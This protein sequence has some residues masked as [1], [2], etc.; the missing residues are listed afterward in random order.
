MI[1]D[2]EILAGIQQKILLSLPTE[3]ETRMV[4]LI[5]EPATVSEC[6]E[7]T[8]LDAISC[9]PDLLALD[10]DIVLEELKEER[11]VRARIQ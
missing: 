4:P 3:K 11:R 9:T 1:S 6:L 10:P 8:T 7:Q 5:S 2:S